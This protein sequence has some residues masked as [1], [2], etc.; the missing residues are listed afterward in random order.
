MK[1]PSTDFPYTGCQ[2]N[3]ALLSFVQLEWLHFPFTLVSPGLAVACCD[4]D[5]SVPHLRVCPLIP[6][7]NESMRLHDLDDLE[8]TESPPLPLPWRTSNFP[9][10]YE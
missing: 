5:G 9:L 4:F 7:T 3:R 1:Q 2:A 10:G 8:N 6:P